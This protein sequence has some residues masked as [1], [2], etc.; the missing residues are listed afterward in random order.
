MV[1]V[2]LI[3]CARASWFGVL[4]AFGWIR[5]RP[6][7]GNDPFRPQT[8]SDKLV[9]GTGD[10]GERLLGSIQI[11]INTTN[12]RNAGSTRARFGR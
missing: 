10:N 8:M 12:L 7:M 5:R 1:R 3:P 2:G 6:D 11:P 4:F 9:A